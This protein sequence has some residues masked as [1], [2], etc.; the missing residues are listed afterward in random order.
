MNLGELRQYVWDYFDL[1]SSDLSTSLLDTWANQGQRQVLKTRPRWAHLEVRDTF[2]TASGTA[3][4][5]LAAT[6]LRSISAADCPDTGPLAVVDEAEA[7]ARYWYGPDATYTNRPQAVS[8][9]TQGKVTVWPTPDGTYDIQ[10]M[11][12]RA[13]RAMSGAAD[14]PDL[15][16]DLGDAVLDWMMHRAYMHQEDPQLAAVH[17]Q[18]FEQTV[19]RFGADEDHDDDARP[20]VLGGGFGQTRR[21]GS[22]RESHWTPTLG[23]FGGF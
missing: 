8:R 11:G 23:Q 2:T 13:P 6:S 20:L 22:A 10:L 7:K 4:Y 1:E 14:A 21:D 3:E 15:P 12:Y 5:A 17:K 16:D 18:L 19:E 9:W